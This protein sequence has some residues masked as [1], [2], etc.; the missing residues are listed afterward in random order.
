MNY[1]S[2]A[3]NPVIREVKALKQKKYREEKGMFFIEGIR[4]VEE[5]L[6]EGVQIHK[7]L[8]SD[9]LA[10]TT[11]GSEILE[12]VNNGGYSVFELPHKLFVEV[13][14]T[15]NPQGIL[16]VLDI[17]DYNIEDIW[18]NK[19][20]FIIL[21]SIQDPGNMG[22][23]IRTADAAGATGVIVSKGCVDVYNPK[24]LR[25]TMGSVFHVPICLS[26]DIFKVMDSMKKRGV[27]ICASHLE[28]NC[29]YFELGYKKD[30]AIIIGNEA[31]GISEEVKNYADVLVR[32]PMPGRA[33][34]LNASV[35][36]GIL[37][38]EVLRKNIGKQ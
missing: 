1:I 38:Y 36:A 37:M 14:D 28:G 13:S 31:N 25:S 4:F 5:A 16:A 23:I 34:S 21:D 30:I 9:K 10:D 6:K 12:K 35:A 22:T 2:S 27:K 7:I 24:V 8:V 29:D 33:E 18:D 20:F 32:I 15:Q 11:S 19:N 17:K 26:E 3:Q